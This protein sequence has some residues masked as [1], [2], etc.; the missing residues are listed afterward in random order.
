VFE[1]SSEAMGS[2]TQKYERITYEGGY[3]HVYLT[4]AAN[5]S[6][7]SDKWFAW[8]AGDESE[9]DTFSTRFYSLVFEE[10][11][12]AGAAEHEAS[13]IAA[14]AQFAAAQRVAA[15]A[16]EREQRD[17][18][19]FIIQNAL[20]EGEELKSWKIWFS[21]GD[22]DDQLPMRV[23]H[24]EEVAAAAEPRTTPL[25]LQ[26]SEMIHV[27]VSR[28]HPPSFHNSLVLH[29]RN[30]KYHRSCPINVAP[31]PR[32]HIIFKQLDKIKNGVFT[33]EKYL[34]VVLLFTEGDDKN[35][36]CKTLYHVSK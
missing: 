31:E 16:K 11:N 3:K 7:S 36:K 28:G 27:S 13:A 35:G 5:S 19:K 24:N 2:F 23:G 12:L 8:L 32:I 33:S 30:G 15:G 25:P 17:V 29:A 4:T 34:P 21:A 1:K 14:A 20:S 18:E 26:S 9:E 10:K 6:K 22:D